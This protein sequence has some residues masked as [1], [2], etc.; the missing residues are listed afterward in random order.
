MARQIFSYCLFNI[1][2]NLSAGVNQIQTIEGSV[3]I[4]G[5]FVSDYG[6]FNE[7]VGKGAGIMTPP[8]SRNFAVG[9]EGV[10]NLSVKVSS[11]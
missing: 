2:L 9:F 11:M 1:C 7:G 8:Q 4:C 10:G 3:A 5:R 6:E